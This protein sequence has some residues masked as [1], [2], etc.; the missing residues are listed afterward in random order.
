MSNYK[1]PYDLT[2]KADA[3]M[4]GTAATS[5]VTTSET[6]NTEGRLLKVGDFGLGSRSIDVG[7]IDLDQLQNNYLSGI[8][9]SS[10]SNPNAPGTG[11]FVVF[12]LHGGGS[13]V[14]QIAIQATNTMSRDPSLKARCGGGTTLENKPW[15]TFYNDANILGTVSQSDG[16]PTGAIIQYV[17]NANGKA[18]RYADGT[19]IAWNDDSS[20]TTDPISFIGTPSNIDNSKLRIGRWFV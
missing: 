4:L 8:Y 1:G 9:K 20:I 5:D 17:S 7:A 13:N 10:S 14:A 11:E 15:A 18:V 6:D 3:D 19:Q 16:V 12:H 2:D